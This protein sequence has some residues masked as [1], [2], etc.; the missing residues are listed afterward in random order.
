MEVV[1]EMIDAVSVEEACA[2]HEAMDLVAFCE[3]ELGEV[4]AVLTGNAG[5][6]CTLC[7]LCRYYR[8]S[9]M[10]AHPLTEQLLPPIA[11]H[12]CRHQN[13]R[14]YQNRQHAFCLVGFNKPDS[15]R[16]VRN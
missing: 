15:G 6:Q 5:D 8:S 7:H 1:V 12:W 11:V 13:V 3:Q 2:S 10:A 4:G 14:I 9:E 16:E